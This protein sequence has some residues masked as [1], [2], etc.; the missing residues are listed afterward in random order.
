MIFAGRKGASSSQ[1]TALMAPG[2]S[3]CAPQ[4]AG[5]HGLSGLCRMLLMRQSG[6]TKAMQG[7]RSWLGYRMLTAAG[8]GVSL[9]AAQR[10][11]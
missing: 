5:E 8:P 9:F 11:A 6:C 4:P 1:H 7:A 10:S 3:V 2:C